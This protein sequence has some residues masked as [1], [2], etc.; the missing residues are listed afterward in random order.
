[1]W[2]HAGT[3]IE[4]SDLVAADN[5]DYEI[6]KFDNG[7]IIVLITLPTP[8][9][10]TEAYFVALVYR[11]QGRAIFSVQEVVTRFIT[12]EYSFNLLDDTPC[13]IE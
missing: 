5:L 8:Q 6:R 4:E 9:A 3:N 13:F 10:I 11:P 2:E 7:M 1:M 12:L